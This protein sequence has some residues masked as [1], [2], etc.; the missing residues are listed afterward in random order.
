MSSATPQADDSR[1]EELLCLRVRCFDGTFYVGVTND[2]DRRFWEHQHEVHPN[3]YTHGRGPLFLEHVSEFDQI[4]DAIAFEKKFKGWSHRKK[5]AFIE[6]NY[7]AMRRWSRGPNRKRNG[8]DQSPCHPERSAKRRVE[9]PPT[10]YTPSMDM[11]VTLI[12][13]E[14]PRPDPGGIPPQPP[15][16]AP[17][18][19]GLPENP[20]ID[21]PSPTQP[22]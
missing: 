20:I 9:G 18:E 3:A 19:P 13:A 14:M 7:E 11:Q 4:L 21:P 15:Q 5:R 12:L 10:G 17:G 2:V 8:Q 1:D 22:T 6:A 16:P